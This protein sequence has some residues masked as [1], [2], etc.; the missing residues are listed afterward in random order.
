MVE[1]E[2]LDDT[3]DMCMCSGRPRQLIE[4]DQWRVLVCSHGCRVDW[5]R[6]TIHQ[7][8]RHNQPKGIPT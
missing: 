4:W 6:V 7:D 1:G 3:C 8:I 5:L 2:T